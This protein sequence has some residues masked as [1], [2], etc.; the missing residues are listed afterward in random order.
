MKKLLATIALVFAAASLFAVEVTPEQ[1][2]A[3]LKEIREKE[4]TA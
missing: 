3:I 1:A 2:V 4:G